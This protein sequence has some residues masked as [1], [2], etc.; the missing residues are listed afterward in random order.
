MARTAIWQFGLITN[1][2]NN[3]SSETFIVR[4]IHQCAYPKTLGPPWGRLLG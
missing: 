3:L 4:F 2:R 1:R